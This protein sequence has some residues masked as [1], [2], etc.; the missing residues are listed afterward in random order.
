VERDPVL[1]RAMGLAPGEQLAVPGDGR[2][3][4]LGLQNLRQRLVLAELLIEAAGFRTE[5]RGGHFRTD[6][7]AAQPFWRCHSL[8]RLGR[9]IST[10]PVIDQGEGRAPL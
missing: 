1:R 4:L 2:Q 6:A 3:V 5:S 7:P 8:Q 9:P 10:Q